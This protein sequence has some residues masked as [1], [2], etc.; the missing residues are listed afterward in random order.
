[1]VKHDSTLKLTIQMTQSTQQKHIHPIIHGIAGLSS[2]VITTTI[3]YPLEAIK[4]RF[5]GTL[6]CIEFL[7][8]I[9]K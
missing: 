8:S 4:T 3:F 9:S 2:S 1:M 5:Q 7:F 6:F